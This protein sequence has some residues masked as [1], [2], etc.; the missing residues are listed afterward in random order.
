MNV[1]ID[2]FSRYRERRIMRFGRAGT[3]AIGSVF[4]C[5]LAMIVILGMQFAASAAEQDRALEQLL[6]K[7]ENTYAGTQFTA[8]F[9]QE[10]TLKAMDITDFASGRVYVRHPGMMRWEYAKPEKQIIITD[11]NRLWIYRPDDNQVMVG[12]APAFFR[13]GKGASFLSDIGLIRKKF[14]ISLQS[15]PTDMFQE[16]KLIP[17]EKTLD[18]AEVRLTVAPETSTVLRVVTINYYGDQTTIEL[19]NYRFTEDLDKSLF[20]FE[21]PEGVDIIQMD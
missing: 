20:S 10:S 5:I 6:E 17:V 16:L 3:V 18:I 11:G 19:I 1:W 9:V 13:D 15:S 8:E 4:R 21:M 12:S 14:E 2:N 7:I